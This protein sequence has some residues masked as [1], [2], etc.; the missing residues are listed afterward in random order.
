MKKAA[1]NTVLHLAGGRTN[2]E[3]CASIQV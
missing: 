2:L 1:P 3:L